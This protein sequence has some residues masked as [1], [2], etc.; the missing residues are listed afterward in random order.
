MSNRLPLEMPS[1]VGSGP[2]HSTRDTYPVDGSHLLKDELA[3]I[4]LL[5][6]DTTLTNN[7]QD[8]L[9]KLRTDHQF[10]AIASY[11]NRTIL[12]LGSVYKTIGY[13]PPEIKAKESEIF[14]V[15]HETISN[16]SSNLQRQKNNIENE[17]E[18]LRQQIQVILSIINDPNGERTF[19]L[20]DRAFI[21]N[22][23]TMYEQG[24]KQQLHEK[25]TRKQNFYLSSPFNISLF[26]E[27]DEDDNLEL[28]VEQQCEQMTKD[29]PDVSLLKLKTKLNDLF[30][31]ILKS[32]VKLFMKL[33]DMN[34]EY[35]EYSASIGITDS[36]DEIIKSF[37]SLEE[38]KQHKNLIIEFEDIIHNV[39]F[40]NTLTHTADE[41]SVIQSSPRRFKLSTT[42]DNIDNENYVSRLRD[43]NYQLVRVIRSLKFTKITPQLLTEIQQKIHTCKVE[44]ERRETVLSETIEKCLEYIELLQLNDDQLITIQKLHN[45]NT[46][47][48]EDVFFEIETLH[49]IRANPIDFG[50]DDTHLE[51]IAKF[52]SLLEKIKDSKERKI[53]NYMKRCQY[54]WEKLNESEEYVSNFISANSSLTDVSLM[55]YKI[56]LNK[57]FLKRSEFIDSFI[58]DSRREI[59][60]YWNKMYFSENQ[61]KA[62]KYYEYDHLMDSSEKEQILMVHE[63]EVA[64]LKEQYQAKESIF[65][66]FDELNELIQDQTFLQE[67]SKD[68]SRLLSKNSCKIL[69]NEERIRK[70]INKSMP[71]LFANLKSEVSAYNSSA[72]KSSKQPI[73]IGGEDFFEKILILESEHLKIGGNRARNN[74]VSPSR[75]TN[76]QKTSPIK[77]RVSSQP[78]NP[79]SRVAK[80]SQTKQSPIKESV[81]KPSVRKEPK[82]TN[83][84][85]IRLTNA[86]NSSMSSNLS[87][88]NLDSPRSHTSL[89]NTIIVGSSTHLQPLNSPL[90]FMS[91]ESKSTLL[92]SS[93]LRINQDI[94]NI[95]RAEEK[96]PLRFQPRADDSQ[97]PGGSRHAELS[98]TRNVDAENSTGLSAL[99]Y[100][101]SGILGDDYS[102]WRDERIKQFQ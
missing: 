79:R 51:F 38:A 13:S 27:E 77:S 73:Q 70:R 12:E 88:S 99:T 102:S 31:K 47:E 43:V 94:V 81:K 85:K 17:C 33:N 34:L 68:S 20:L 25:L 96:K 26:D 39:K 49:F 35:F 55:N 7:S 52:S 60:M 28:S 40:K 50:L 87:T 53:Q 16:F 64:M 3:H 58:V 69:L 75:S 37:P 62:F 15:L 63:Q 95:S 83:P 30:M 5:D 42:V 86:F 100:D 80:R 11:V 29:I 82:Y 44:V 101:S 65:N 61:R 46:N 72:L 59:E 84:T 76:N 8:K 90:T 93:P 66:L 10:D 57:L 97:S 92:R 18:W 14:T 9:S 23:T 67:S 36:S 1:R 21:F 78:S 74:N 98:T 24:Y 22:D 32:F 2:W 41:S 4:D 6:G 89:S 56:E 71:K 19:S 48:K 91:P 54:L 45:L